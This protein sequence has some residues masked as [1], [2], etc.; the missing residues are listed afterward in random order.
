MNNLNKSRLLVV[1]NMPKVP[2]IKLARLAWKPGLFAEL[3]LQDG[4]IA[5]TYL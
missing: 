5:N 4:V 1:R 2:L 3:P